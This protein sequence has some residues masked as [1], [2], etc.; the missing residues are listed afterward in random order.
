MAQAAF[1]TLAA[2]LVLGAVLL[3]AIGLRS[4]RF[5]TSRGPLLGIAILFAALVVATGAFA[6]IHAEEEQDHHAAELAEEREQAAGERA[7]RLRGQAQ[8][9]DPAQDEPVEVGGEQVFEGAG[10]ASCHALEA[11]GSTATVGPGLDET[12]PDRSREEIERLIVDPES[13]VTP[14]FPAGVMPGNYEETLSA[15]ELEALVE[16]LVQSTQ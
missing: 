9:V 4:E 6:W 8:E 13:E 10:C 12:L 1:F 11:A 14:G 2:I 7:E 3:S 15:A 16:F 5:P